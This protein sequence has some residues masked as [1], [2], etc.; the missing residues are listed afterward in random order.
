MEFS[1]VDIL[2][3]PSPLAAGRGLD[4]QATKFQAAEFVGCAFETLGSRSA[5]YAF[6]RNLVTSNMLNCLVPS[7]GRANETALRHKRR[8]S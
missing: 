1:P 6:I 8:N 5:A 2:Q 7:P 4:T 3:K